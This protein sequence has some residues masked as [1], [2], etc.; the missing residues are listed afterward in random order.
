MKKVKALIQNLLLLICLAIALFSAWKL[1]GYYRGYRDGEKEYEKLTEY[2]K[3]E[4]KE[5]KE[6]EDV[7]PISVNF[8]ELKKINEDV[9]G[10][11]YIPDTEINYPIVQGSDNSWYLHHTFEN[12]NNFSGAIFMDYLCQR[13]FSS[14]NSIIYGHNLKNGAMF[15]TLKKMYDL[16][17]NSKADYKEHPFIWILTP[18]ATMEYQIFAAREIDV[19]ADKDVYTIE[20][21]SEEEYEAWV[22][23]QIQCSQYETGID[24][25]IEE[26]VLTL[27]TCTS[28]SEDGRFIVLATQMQSSNHQ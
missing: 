18:D 14:D 16:D 25:S 2:V 3:V 24:V 12:Q 5:E 17:Y 4:S 20:F 10:W 11:I 21:A 7:C 8:E 22:E 15:G 6:E 27:S 28:R 1:Y 19:N 9:V 13:D 26:P 23:K